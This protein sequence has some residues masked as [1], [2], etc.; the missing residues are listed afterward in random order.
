M[1][2]WWYVLIVFV[3]VATGASVTVVRFLRDNGKA[4]RAF[5]KSEK[6]QRDEFIRWLDEY[7]ERMRDREKGEG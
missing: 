5:D 7:K 6:Q 3:S 2:F 4:R 1:G